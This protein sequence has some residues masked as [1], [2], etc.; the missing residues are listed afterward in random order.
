[1]FQPLTIR[2][3]LPINKESLPEGP[4]LSS[5]PYVSKPVVTPQDA[6]A[7]QVRWKIALLLAAQMREPLTD[8]AIQAIRR[9][10]HCLVGKWLLSEDTRRLCGIPEHRAMIDLHV[11]FHDQLLKVAT[12]LRA[13]NFDQAERLVNQPGPF[14]DASNALANAIMAL[15][16]RTGR[17]LAAKNIRDK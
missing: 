14:Q 17:S 9:P 3:D 16:R 7:S 1:M 4:E 8:R 2:P 10:D 13:G 5:T 6:I 12:L 11:A 15:D